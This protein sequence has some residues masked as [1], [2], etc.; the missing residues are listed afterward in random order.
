MPT[1]QN[2][3]PSAGSRLRL[4]LFMVSSLMNKTNLSYLGGLVFG[5]SLDECI[6]IMPLLFAF[7]SL[8]PLQ[9]LLVIDDKG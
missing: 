8:D 3:M 5:L 6:C 2:T 7:E 4:E 9:G 1:V